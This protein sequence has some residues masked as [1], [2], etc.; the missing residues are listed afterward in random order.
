MI[1]Y[2]EIENLPKEHPLVVKFWEQ[3][4]KMDEL[5]LGEE[6]TSGLE[7]EE[8]L[9]YFDRYVAGDR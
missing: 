1:K 5:N 7:D 8:S 9:V 2:T 6:I 3:E 4:R